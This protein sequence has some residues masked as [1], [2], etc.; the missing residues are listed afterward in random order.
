MPILNPH[1]IITSKSL[2]PVSKSLVLVPKQ[3]TLITHPRQLLIVILP[4]NI[5]LV[6]SVSL[7][8]DPPVGEL[9]GHNAEER[10][11]GETEPDAEAGWVA[12]F[13]GVEEDVL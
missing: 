11:G 3:R 12:G 7:L 13:F 4:A 10:H 6:H 2:L 8:V 5:L 9:Q 1:H